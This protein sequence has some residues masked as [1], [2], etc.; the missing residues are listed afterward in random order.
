M[1]GSIADMEKLR[2]TARQTG[3]TFDRAAELLSPTIRGWPEKS[4]F[5]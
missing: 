2:R 3:E 4:H 1:G 5:Q